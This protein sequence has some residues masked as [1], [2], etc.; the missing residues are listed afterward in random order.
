MLRKLH[1]DE[2]GR[3]F[4]NEID[5]TRGAEGEIRVILGKLTKE[6]QQVVEKRIRNWVYGE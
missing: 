2:G 3:L 4:D 6:E 5:R 1:L